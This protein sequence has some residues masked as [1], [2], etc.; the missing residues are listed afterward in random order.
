[1]DPT[2]RSPCRLTVPVEVA[3]FSCRVSTPMPVPM[4]PDTVVVPAPEMSVTSSAAPLATP[5]IDATVMF[6]APVP[7]SRVRDWP[8]ATVTA[9]RVMSALS[10][11]MVPAAFTAPAVATSPAVKLR[12]SDAASPSVVVPVLANVVAVSTAPPPSSEMP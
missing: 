10:V 9:P 11:P 3:W 8:L 1:M 4:D 12:V 5:V 2:E 7:V 6:P